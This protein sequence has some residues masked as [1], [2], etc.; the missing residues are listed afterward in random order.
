M[1]IDPSWS[2]QM[3]ADYLQQCP[4]VI[5]KLK[6]MQHALQTTVADEGPPRHREESCRTPKGSGVASTNALGDSEEKEDD[7]R[8]PAMNAEAHDHGSLSHDPIQRHRPLCTADTGSGLR[9]IGEATAGGP[10][11]AAEGTVS[12]ETSGPRG[13]QEARHERR[14]ESSDVE[15][16]PPESV[17]AVQEGGI[18]TDGR[19]RD[20]RQDVMARVKAL[21]AEQGSVA[22]FDFRG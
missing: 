2:Q 14:E 12:V 8:A 9:E 21:R 22:N 6:V 20:H 5:S 10:E 11:G 1:T 13:A 18:G 15:I 16:T 19:V 4:Y 7:E 3:R 17:T